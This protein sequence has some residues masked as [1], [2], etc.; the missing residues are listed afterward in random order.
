MEVPVL[1]KERSFGNV[2]LKWPDLRIFQEKV[3]MCISHEIS[4]FLNV[5]NC[6]FK[7]KKTLQIDQ[8]EC[9]SDIAQYLQVCNLYPA[10]YKV[11]RYVLKQKD[12][13]NGDSLQSLQS[14]N[15]GNL[16]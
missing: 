14:H 10:L 11:Q 6:Q 9:S 2:G 3:E 13:K 8:N 5:G 12:I 4:W 15:G 7:K 16:L 1:F